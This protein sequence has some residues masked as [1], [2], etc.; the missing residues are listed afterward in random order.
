MNVEVLNRPDTPK[1]QDLSILIADKHLL[2]AESIGCILSEKL[3]C[4]AKGVDSLAAARA[5]AEEDHYDMIFYDSALPDDGGIESIQSL[6]SDFPDSAV[7]LFTK[8]SDLDFLSAALKVGL[9]GYLPKSMSLNSLMPTVDLL[10]SGEIYIPIQ[11]MKE[12]QQRA[13]SDPTPKR[14][15]C[16]RDV[17]L[18]RLI[19]T[20]MS[21]KEIGGRIGSNE[22]RV[23]MLLRTLYHKIGANNRV[24][25]LNIAKELGEI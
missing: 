13:V 22:N 4:S 20:G 18:L 23:K 11:T 12:M 2:V 21:N 6:V 19:E 25:A 15:L 17:T 5:A 10:K 3:N 14:R 1:G 16:D 9:R 7:V 8:C 24:H